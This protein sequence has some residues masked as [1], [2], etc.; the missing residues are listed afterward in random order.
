MTRILE[1]KEHRDCKTVY[2][3]SLRAKSD[4]VSQHQLALDLGICRDTIRKRIRLY[5][6]HLDALSAEQAAEREVRKAAKAA[7]VETTKA[8]LESDVVAELKRQNEL[9]MQ[10]LN[11]QRSGIQ[12]PIRG[13]AEDEYVPPHKTW[14]RIGVIPDMHAPYNHPDT[15]EFIEAVKAKYRLQD[16]ICLGDETD[17]HA[18]SFH[19]SSP[20]LAS[21]GPELK[22]ARE[23]LH[24][25]EA[26]IPD[27]D[28][29]HSNHGSLVYRRAFDAGLPEMVIRS[30]REILFGERRNDGSVHLPNGRGRGW[31]WH[32]KL[33][34]EI[35]DSGNA[36]FVHG[37][38]ANVRTAVGHAGESVVQGHHHSVCDLSYHQG[39]GGDRFGVTVGCLIDHKSLAFA[40]GKT[41][42]KKPVLGMAII[43]DGEPHLIRMKT[44]PDGR[45]IGRLAD[46]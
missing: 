43:I 14:T 3:A 7:E 1:G 6:R 44:R 38:S 5:E 8:P 26:M 20:D 40:Y 39:D 23:F 18:I 28:I 30:Y 34:I 9:L 36:V 13:D 22:A 35:P 42:V 12:A 10:M 24:K 15:L 41:F 2:E 31:R 17:G 11:E 4:S 16:W 29:V 33:E 46:L 37:Y 27:M 32:E 21:A 19:N 25:L 45:W